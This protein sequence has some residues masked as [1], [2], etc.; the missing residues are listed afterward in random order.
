MANALPRKSQKCAQLTGSTSNCVMA[1]PISN[2]QLDKN[3]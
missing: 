2:K 1:K 3:K